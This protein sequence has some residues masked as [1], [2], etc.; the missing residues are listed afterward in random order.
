MKETFR[1]V[2]VRIVVSGSPHPEEVDT[3][4]GTT[5]TGVKHARNFRG[6]ATRALRVFRLFRRKLIGTVRG[7]V[8]NS[9]E[10]KRAAPRSFFWRKRRRASRAGGGGEEEDLAAARGVRRRGRGPLED[11]DELPDASSQGTPAGG[12]DDEG[13]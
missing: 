9:K 3:R 13:G 6:E 4:G 8:E 7:G 5:Q 2:H 11:D 10:A 12:R 1:S